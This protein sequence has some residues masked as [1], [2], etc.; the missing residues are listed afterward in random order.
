MGYLG[1]T[2][3]A[4][5]TLVCYLSVV[6]VIMT[7]ELYGSVADIRRNIRCASSTIAQQ[8]RLLRGTNLLDRVV[9][10]FSVCEY[11]K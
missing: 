2:G 9:V 6:S 10:R 5:A 1:P 7:A 3:R 4:E 8:Q 11:R